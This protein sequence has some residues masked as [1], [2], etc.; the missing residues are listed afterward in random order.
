MKKSLQHL[1]LGGL[2]AAILVVGGPLNAQTST[3]VKATDNVKATDPAAKPKRDWYPFYGTVD[4]VD[5][6]AKTVA[7][8]KKDGERVLKTNSQTKLEQD[9]KPASLASL[10][11]GYYLHGKLHKIENV[12]FI[13]DAKIELEAPAK[14]GTNA[15]STVAAPVTDDASTNAVKK[16]K[17]KKTT[18]TP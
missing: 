17:K 5:K 1:L 15:V 4:T 11:P 6:S 12:E 9:G 8:K 10:K 3:K 7:L 14:K 18:G 2:C 13:L 16:A